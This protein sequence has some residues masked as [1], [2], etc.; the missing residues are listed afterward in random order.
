M[1]QYRNIYEMFSE[2]LKEMELSAVF[3]PAKLLV[4]Q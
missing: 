2:I 3:H 1:S 4:S